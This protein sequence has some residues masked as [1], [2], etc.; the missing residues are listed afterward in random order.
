M[1]HIADIGH[2]CGRLE[3]IELQDNGIALRALHARVLAQKLGDKDAI[4]FA[5]QRIVTLIALQIRALI[6]GV[7]LPRNEPAARAA[8]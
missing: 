8:T 5:L 4:R 7:V 1:D 2:L 3:M 6:V